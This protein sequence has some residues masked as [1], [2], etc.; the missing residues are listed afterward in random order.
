MKNGEYEKIIERHN[1]IYKFLF[2][3]KKVEVNIAELEPGAESRLFV[4]NGEEIHIVIEGELEYT[5][6]DKIYKLKKGDILWHKSTL[7]HK[8]KNNSDSKVIYLTIGTPPTF[9]PSMT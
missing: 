6:D 5:V 4:H 9:K 2:Q 3:T 7:G 1:K 8:A